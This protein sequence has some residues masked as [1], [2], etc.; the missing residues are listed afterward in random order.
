MP[1][2]HPA[3]ARLP[4]GG[5]LL[6]LFTLIPSTIVIPIIRRFV[7][8]T[9]PDREWLI[10]AFMAVNL[11][12]ACLGGPLMAIRAD[13]LAQ[14]RS[15]GVTLAVVDALASLAVAAALPWPLMLVARFI[16]GAASVGAVSIFMGSI[17]SRARTSAAMGLVASSI[18]FALVI[19]IPLG[20]LLARI[21]LS[22]PLV[23]G[24][25]FGLV[26]AVMALRIFPPAW[27]PA[28]TGQS[29][30][31]LWRSSRQLR[32]PVLAVALERF[33]VGAFI[34]TIQLH[35]HHTLGVADTTVSRWLTIFLVLFGLAT[36]PMAR[37][38]ERVGKLP[39]VTAG[40]VVYGLACAS[41]GLWDAALLGG[42]LAVAAVGAAAIYGPALG[43]VAMAVSEG[44]RS[45]AMGLMNAAG[46]FGMFVGNVLAGA[47]IGLLVGH[48]APRA[49]SY[50]V[51]FAVAGLLQVGFGVALAVTSRA[52][53]SVST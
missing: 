6:V 5:A 29:L 30:G 40:A 36:W 44:S 20:A 1:E 49:G 15:T 10:H 35:G 28:A 48:G 38:G 46:T 19:S 12:G 37:L 47:G 3:K 13:R 22:V 2:V 25:A 51:I 16:Q 33:G 52:R 27:E 50:A 31:D 14:R 18:I 45:S 34:V 42:A 8:D 9:W 24:S 32:V 53:T 17:R 21:S 4:W 41:F 39:L 7:A 23:V 26:A 11:L 43:L